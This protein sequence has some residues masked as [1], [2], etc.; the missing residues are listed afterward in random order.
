MGQGERARAAGAR[1][2]RATA[3]LLDMLTE[4]GYVV[5][6]SLSVARGRADIDHLLVGSRGIV[7]LDSKC[8]RPAWYVTA[9]GRAW[10]TGGPVWRFVPG[11]SQSLAL[12]VERL[13]RAG[14][15]VAGAVV[16]TSPSAAGR[17]HAR[18]LRYAGA[19]AVLPARR[20][21]RRAARMAGRGGAD[22]AVVAAV[23]SWM[24]ANQ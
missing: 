11:E 22:L 5:F 3:R 15:P 18:L 16:A 23:D 24:E 4:D 7:V 1:A 14:L 2:E 13:R 9:F 12:S 8:W 19:R 10:R 21:V 17:V 6:H 20:A